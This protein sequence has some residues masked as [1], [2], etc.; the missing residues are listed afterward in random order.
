[1]KISKYSIIFAS[2]FVILTGLFSFVFAKYYPFLFKSIIYHCPHL[3]CSKLVRISTEIGV[4][5][6]QFMILMIILTIIKLIADYLKIYLLRKNI[7][8]AVIKNP[9]ID[10]LFKSLNLKG[11]V[12]IVDNQNPF[13]FCFGFL[14]PRIILSSKLIKIMNQQELNAILNHEKYHLEHK[15]A[16]VSLL[17]KIVQ[18][19]FPFFPFISDC[20]KKY[21]IE[22]ETK[23]DEMAI[24]IGDGRFHL[25][26][27]LKKM[28]KFDISPA[29]S[30][31]PSFT[32]VETLEVRIRS[33]IKKE[34][35]PQMFSF[36]SI[37]LS[38]FSL[39]IVIALIFAPLHIFSQGENG[40]VTCIGTNSCIDSCLQNTKY[41]IDK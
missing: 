29:Y 3:D 15:D 39:V 19:L 17:A 5:V 11:K 23:A 4:T 18:S 41:P 31:I 22:K 34:N 2:L 28:I 24:K 20:V 9:N 13:A 12:L 8:K 7:I 21:S 38:M 32:G 25:I 40:I 37:F 10:S 6:F 30:T 35:K 16:L 14:N 1:M 33:L 26:S 36:N 27:A